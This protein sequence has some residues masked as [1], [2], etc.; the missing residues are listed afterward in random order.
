MHHIPDYKQNM[1]LFTKEF[2][3]RLDL[4]KQ[5]VLAKSYIHLRELNH[6]CSRILLT[7]VKSIKSVEASGGA[8]KIR[9]NPITATFSLISAEVCS[10]PATLFKFLTY[11]FI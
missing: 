8:Y 7:S 10:L 6:N 4:V 9:E 5:K 11:S 1:W 2:K 3:A